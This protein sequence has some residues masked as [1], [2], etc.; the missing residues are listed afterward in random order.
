MFLQPSSRSYHHFFR[1]SIEPMSFKSKANAT[2]LMADVPLPSIKKSCHSECVY[3]YCCGPL[4]IDHLEYKNL[5]LESRSCSHS[6]IL[7]CKV[8]LYYK[9][10]LLI[11][12][13][14]GLMHLSLTITLFFINGMNS[15]FTSCIQTC[16]K[17][18]RFMDF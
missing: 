4:L 6:L 2:W 5:L 3:F 13:I 14:E 18:L 15:C 1:D 10:Y 12:W 11:Y 9:K 16:A 7:M 8:F 17:L